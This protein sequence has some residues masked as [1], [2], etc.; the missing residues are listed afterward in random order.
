MAD[1]EQPESIEELAGPAWVHRA[2]LVYTFAR[3][4][5]PGGQAVNKL[6]T[7]ARLRVPL[8]A[9]RGLDGAAVGR[10]R[11]LAGRRLTEAEELHFASRR[12]RSQIANRRACLERLKELVAAAVAPPRVRRKTRPGRGAV[13]S[14]LDE[15]RKQGERKRRRRW[16]GDRDG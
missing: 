15:K 16:E 8:A 14:R 7:A 4:R 3:S 5:G 10:L 2:D 13:E 12:H 9:I 11:R 6:S 1:A